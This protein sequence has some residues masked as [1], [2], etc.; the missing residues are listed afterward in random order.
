MSIVNLG[1][2]PPKQCGIATFSKDLKNSL[3]INGE[4]VQ[5]IAISDS[6]YNYNYGEEVIF[7]IKQQQKTDYQQ[8][9]LLINN[10][11]DIELV[12]VQ[13]EYGIYGGE[14]GNYILNFTE[15]LNKPYIVVTHTVLP[16]PQKRQLNTLQKL[17]SRAEGVVCMTEHSAHLLTRL[18]KV[19]PDKIKVISHGVPPFKKENPEIL[20]AKYGLTGYQIISTFGLIGPGKGLELGIR[21]MSEVVKEYPGTKYLILGQTHPMLKSREGEKYRE[22]LIHL[23]KEL[24]LENHVQFVNKFLSDEELG[25]YL[26]LTDIYLSPY[27]NKDQAVS[28]TLTFAIGCGRAIV[29]TSYT[30]AL[31]VLKN[32]RGLLASKAD[33]HELA[34]LIK[35]ILGSRELKEK[36]QSRAYELGQKWSW[37]SIG[38]EYTCFIRK[39]IQNSKGEQKLNYAGL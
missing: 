8:A 30:Y 31:E 35:M 36:L 20:K 25:E 10:T 38:Q 28:G 14:S 13:H 21:A 15:N 39:I 9:A 5:I 32:E 17:C 6:N 23:I 1:T 24:N 22:M 18:Y 33:P 2:F 26:Y 4:K 12:I 34:C 11:P 19:N 29:S 7:N 27:P 37:P 16:R 3:E